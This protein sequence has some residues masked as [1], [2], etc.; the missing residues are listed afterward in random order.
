MGAQG[1]VIFLILGFVLAGSAA[2]SSRST[3]ERLEDR[4]S[5]ARPRPAAY[6]ADGFYND[7][8]FAERGKPGPDTEFFFKRCSLVGRNPFTTASEWECT[9]PR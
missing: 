3:R 8:E 9:E 7:G 6:G 2:C 4:Q 1:A 5:S